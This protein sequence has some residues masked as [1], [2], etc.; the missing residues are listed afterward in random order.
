MEL[1]WAAEP[2]VG[3]PPS[4]TL[5]ERFQSSNHMGCSKQPKSVGWK[6]K[7]AI[8]WFHGI[9]RLVRLSSSWDALHPGASPPI[10]AARFA[11]T[12]PR[13]DVN[14]VNI[15]SVNHP[16]TSFEYDQRGQP[17]VRLESTYTCAWSSL[18][19]LR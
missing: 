6:V 12:P 17:P 3:P 7:D 8:V 16:E 11:V 9:G 5:V 18:S 15:R 19:L 4:P 14:T 1:Y 13:P 10:Q 2:I